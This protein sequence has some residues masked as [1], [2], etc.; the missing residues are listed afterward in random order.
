[1]ENEE[2]VVWKGR[3]SQIVN[4]WPFVFSGLV[5]L[6][7]IALAFA[8][9]FFLIGILLPAAYAGWLWLS[10]KCRI[11]EFTSERM[12]LYEGV[13]NQEINE[14]ELYRVK[15]TK[16]QKP[17]WLRIF[18]LS[19]IVLDTSD[20]SCPIIEIRAIRD[21]AAIREKLRKQVEILRDKKRVR[22]VDF[23]GSGG[24]DFADGDDF[25]MV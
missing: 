12:R 4:F 25:E 16:I 10:T 9:P 2:S 1:M 24:D 13:L 20:R 6:A 17:F 5:A 23:E 18:G 7:F 8:N 15:D 11:F 14:V 22:E 21:G 19:T 3:S